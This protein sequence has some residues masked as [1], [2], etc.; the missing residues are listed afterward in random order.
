MKGAAVPGI[1]V[2][3]KLGNE[4]FIGG[5]FTHIPSISKMANPGTALHFPVIPEQQKKQ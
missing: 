2:L 1:A 4:K 3:L 5:F